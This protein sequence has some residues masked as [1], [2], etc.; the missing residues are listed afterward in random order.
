MLPGTLQ[1]KKKI[2]DKKPQRKGKKQN[3]ACQGAS[4]AVR[5]RATLD[6]A[7]EGQSRM[8]KEGMKRRIIFHSLL[9]TFFWLLLKNISSCHFYTVAV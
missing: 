5:R 1:A 9:I 8:E 6:T 4:G 7:D 2:S 3:V